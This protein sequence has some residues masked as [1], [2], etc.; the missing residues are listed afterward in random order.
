MRKLFKRLIQWFKG[1]FKSKDLSKFKHNR[2]NQE[3][4]FRITYKGKKMLVRQFVR[5]M[6]N[7]MNDINNKGPEYNRLLLVAGYNAGG[8]EMC[9]KL[10]QSQIEIYIDKNSK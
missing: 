2:Y 6:S 4:A 3:K 10:C 1:L 8:F 7:Q 5:L 9:K